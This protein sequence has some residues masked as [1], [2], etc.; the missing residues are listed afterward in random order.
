MAKREKSEIKKANFSI[1]HSSRGGPIDPKIFT[2]ESPGQEL[3]D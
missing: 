1:F 2:R 3:E